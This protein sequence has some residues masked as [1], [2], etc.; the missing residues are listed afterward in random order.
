[1]SSRRS[2]QSGSSRISD[3]QIIQL[4]K[5]LQQLVP[6]LR[7]HHSEKEFVGRR[8][9]ASLFDHFGSFIDVFIPRK[10]SRAGFRFG[11][12]RFDSETAAG[13]TVL[14]VDGLK[15]KDKFLHVKRVAFGKAA[16][17]LQP[18]KVDRDGVLPRAGE[19]ALMFH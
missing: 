19:A 10:R 9:L 11:F 12:I 17:G 15:W 2:R 18:R 1:M 3:D 7:N 6:E 14:R 16:P 13:L 5:K 8:E 4:I